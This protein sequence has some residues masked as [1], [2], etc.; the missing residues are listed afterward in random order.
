ML[1]AYMIPYPVQ[2]NLIMGHKSSR[3]KAQQLNKGAYKEDVLAAVNYATS[4]GSNVCHVRRV[5][6]YFFIGPCIK[7][8]FVDTLLKCS[9][10]TSCES[11]CVV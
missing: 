2:K 4:K 10:G 1:K 3:L 9:G 11:L 8:G 7:S 6:P 5:L